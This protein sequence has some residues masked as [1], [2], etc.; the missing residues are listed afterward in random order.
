MAEGPG[1]ERALR[2]FLQRLQSGSRVTNA[3]R[4]QLQQVVNN[5]SSI[6]EERHEVPPPPVSKVPKTLQEFLDRGFHR[7][8]GTQE[9]IPVYT[10]AE[11]GLHRNGWNERPFEVGNDLGR[12]TYGSARLVFKRVDMA[13]APEQRRLAALKVQRPPHL[14]EDNWLPLWMEVTVMRALVHPNIISIYSHFLVIPKREANESEVLRN[15]LRPQDEMWILMEYATA[16]TLHT[17]INRYFRSGITISEHGARYYMLQIMKAVEYLHDREISHNDIHEHNI[18]LSYTGNGQDK[19][20]K[21]AD[22]GAAEIESIHPVSVLYNIDIL[23]CRGLLNFM[24]NPHGDYRGLTQDAIDVFRI[25]LSGSVR[26]LLRM[27]WF[28]HSARP[29]SPPPVSSPPRSQV[30]EMP[31]RE[32][33]LSW[34]Q[35]PLGERPASPVTTGRMFSP[36]TAQPYA[37]PITMPAAS[38]R[39]GRNTGPLTPSPRSRSTSPALVAWSPDRPAS[40]TESLQWSFSPP[41]AAGQLQVPGAAAR[42]RSPSPVPVTNSPDGPA[43]RGSGASPQWSFASS[44]GKELSKGLQVPAAA[45]RSLSPSHVLPPESPDRPASR[46]SAA[47]PQ[48]SFSS[49]SGKSGKGLQV[50]ETIA[51]SRTP[52]PFMSRAT[53]QTP[54]P[55]SPK[56]RSSSSRTPSLGPHQ[57]IEHPPVQSEAETPATTSSRPSWTGRIRRSISSMGHAVRDRMGRLICFRRGHRHQNLEES[58]QHQ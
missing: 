13:K 26:Q 46:G 12:G 47:S 39:A 28:R 48:W 20:C 24:L 40:R 21:L 53:P 56:S 23:S 1:S 57:I 27:K 32:S 49:S 17:E 8:D 6:D 14:K 38:Q 50:P 55:V 2:L 34:A 41:A 58:G 31:V 10:R 11:V 54:A 30:R 44:S 42:S 43:S 7:E 18:F 4:R 19:I 22:F 3:D 15:R 52:S 25:L 33:D 29:P 5:I 51:R 36:P 16:G 35:E 45:A 9:P 37:V